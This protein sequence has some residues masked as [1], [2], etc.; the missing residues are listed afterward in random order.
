MSDK[1]TIELSSEF[2]QHP[3]A[4][5]RTVFNHIGNIALLGECNICAVCK[6]LIKEGW[7]ELNDEGQP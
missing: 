5:K 2:I 1:D 6:D 7:K 3:K 4:D